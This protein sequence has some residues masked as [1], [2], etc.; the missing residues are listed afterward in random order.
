MANGWASWWSPWCSQ[1]DLH[2]FDE[3]WALFLWSHYLPTYCSAKY[4][5]ILH[6][7][8]N[9]WTLWQHP[10]WFGKLRSHSPCCTFPHEIKHGL[11]GSVLALRCAIFRGRMM[12]VKWNWS[13]PL[14]CIYFWIFCFSGVLELF[15]SAPR[16][17]QALLPM[18]RLL[19]NDDGRKLFCHLAD[20]TW[21]STSSF[22]CN[23]A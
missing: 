9:N 3:V 16:L 6:E 19:G 15:Q 5:S 14:Q 2:S 11:R 8:R 7:M 10:T 23:I 17:P 18:R 13:Y 20:A 1:E 4:F 21:I 22:N 12:W